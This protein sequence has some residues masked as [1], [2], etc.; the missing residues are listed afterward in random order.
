MV[1]SHV[2]ES[3][4]PRASLAGRPEALPGRDS[5]LGVSLTFLGY[6][7]PIP[8]AGLIYEVLRGLFPYRAAVHV[9]DLHALE[10]QLFSI[11]TADGPR[12][13]SDVISRLASPWL[14][15]VCGA[16]YLLFLIEVVVTAMY[17]F[18]RDRPRMLQVSLGFLVVNV[19]GWAVWFLYPAAPPW[20]VDQYGT[21]PA[22]LQAASSPAGLLRID[23][24]LRVPIAATFYAKSANVFGAMPSLHVAYASLVACVAAPLGG[25]LRIATIGFALSM[26]FSAVY[27]R[28]HYILD[29]VA[30]V[31][32][33]VP[34]SLL[35]AALV[36]RYAPPAPGARA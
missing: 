16:T 29:V 25:W 8:A 9:G 17:L 36:R 19:V 10:A 24:L 4:V 28:H 32:L 23:A 31:A 22:V 3:A 27:L 2:D 18:Y 14:D 26:V 13:L 30:G 15:L 35:V 6:L 12:A 33:A 5:R 1:S 21:G 11:S 34:V 20:Y 7:L